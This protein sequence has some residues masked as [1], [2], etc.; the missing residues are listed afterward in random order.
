MLNFNEMSDKIE[1]NIKEIHPLL[2]VVG[3]PYKRDNKHSIDV[4][5]QDSTI[6]VC[7]KILNKC[8][9]LDMK[10]WYIREIN[11]F[12]SNCSASIIS[13]VESLSKNK[14]YIY[15]PNT[16]GT[17]VEKAINLIDFNNDMYEVHKINTGT[18]RKLIHATVRLLIAVVIMILITIFDTK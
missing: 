5:I 17:Q 3:E 4:F 8:I 10:D 13:S 12:K 18:G 6:I 16:S 9:E 15:I 1:L 2:Y 7:N 14:A 11:I